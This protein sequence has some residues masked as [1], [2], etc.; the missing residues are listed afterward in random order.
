MLQAEKK[1]MY[2]RPPM[3]A[4]D[5]HWQAP[6]EG[7]YKLNVDAATTENGR[8]ELGCIVRDHKGDIIVAAHKQ[9]TTN[10]DAETSEAAAVVYGVKTALETG[11]WS[12]EVEMDCL[13]VAEALKKKTRR[14]SYA[15]T[16]I[17][18]TLS[19]SH[20][21][22]KISFQYCNRAGNQVAH[23]LAKLALMSSDEVGWIEDGPSSILPLVDVDKQCND[24]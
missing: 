18:E 4:P 23:T 13:N 16:F 9:V 7:N 19:L 8:R 20:S 3:N 22:L 11:L 10:W 17:A 1:K 2:P 21:F 12:L 6:T 5:I 24:A 15:S 14:S